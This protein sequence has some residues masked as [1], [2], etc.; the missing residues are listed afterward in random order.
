MLVNLVEQWQ[1]GETAAFERLFLQYK[2]MVLRTVLSMNADGHEAEDI[3][4]MAFI[5]AYQSRSKFNGDD[6]A[7]KRW[8]YR[9]TINLC[10]DTHR[11][12]RSYLHLEQLKEK[13]FEPSNQSS[14][15]KVEA[16]DIVWQ[17]MDCLDSKHRSVVVLRYLHEMPY[18]EISK[19]LD[20]P[21]GTVK[22]RLNT[23]M[24][25][26]RRKLVREDE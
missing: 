6:N 24:R 11:K 25:V 7:F 10:V 23:A 1:K 20:I 8:L 3:T 2:D 21:L 18:E 9:I 12:K 22:S 16:K 15:S 5:K 14:Y 26:M 17:A 19:T 4:Q 13:G